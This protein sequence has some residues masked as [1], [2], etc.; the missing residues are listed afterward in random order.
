MRGTGGVTLAAMTRAVPFALLPR[1]AVLAGLASGL[2]TA[3]L[4]EAPLQS[5]RPAARHPDLRAR[6]AS[7]A[8]GLIATAKLGGS[9]AFAVLD[10]GTGELLEAR[11]PEEPLPPA[12]ALKAM[13][14]LY[15]R[16]SLGPA[17]RFT[18]RV[19]GSG[20]V[21]GGVLEGDLILSGGGDPTLDALALAAMV[22]DLRAQGLARITGRFLVD[23]SALPALPLIDPGQPEQAGY[24]PGISGLNLNFNRVFFEWQR[25]GGSYAVTMDARAGR[26]R[27]PVGVARMTVVDRGAPLFTYDAQGGAEAWTVARAALGENGGR[28]LPVRRPGLYAGDVFRALAAER[29]LTLPAPEPGRATGGDVLARAESSPLDAILADMLEYS[30]NLTAEVLGLSASAARGGDA[31]S[32]AGSAATMAGWSSIRHGVH[33]TRP[34]DHSG[35]G[36]ESRVT[37]LGMA[38][39]L[40]SAGWEGPLSGL[41]R[42]VRFADDRG[43]RI[44]NHPVAATAK[45]GTLNFVSALAGYARSGEGRPLAF[46]ILGAD[47]ARRATISSQE[48]ERPLGARP[49]AV[50]SRRLQQR[51]IE[52]WS[53]AHG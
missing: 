16:E 28:W 21:A 45:T 35:L 7:G 2:A 26:L 51:L 14:A 29:G 24:N 44:P 40:V 3:A 25:S 30:T 32:L 41:M 22:D 23:E 6:A 13:T 9:L 8:E 17:H 31:R 20:P 18:T 39:F 53:V 27:P 1:R 4:A 47:L 48:S 11:A 34:V 46:A 42:A 43:N 12:S 19:L 33:G 49:W 5:P 37:A 15:A 38:R 10:A 50:R 36:G 52:A